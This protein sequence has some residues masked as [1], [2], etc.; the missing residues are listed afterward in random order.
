MGYIQ[1]RKGEIMEYY[2]TSLH[3]LRN[4]A[5]AIGVKSP[6]IY[7]KAELIVKIKQVE[8]G[9]IK[10]YYS[11]KGRPAYG[12]DNI[13]QREKKDQEHS[14]SKTEK[15]AILFVIESIKNFLDG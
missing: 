1:K 7:N 2:T 10:P 15:Q 8:S 12:D 3:D 11:N 9:K 14:K 4:Y 13:N 6:C 5:R